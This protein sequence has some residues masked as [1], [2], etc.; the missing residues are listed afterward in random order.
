MLIPFP[1]IFF[2]SAFV[3]DLTFWAT[4]K[5]AW[6]TAAIWLIGA[7]VIMAL[8]AALAGLTDVVGDGRISD[9]TDVWWHVGGNVLIVFDPDLQLIK[10]L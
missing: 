3:C 7:G 5:S 8:L 10:P 1:V 4:A 2:V 9:L 6:S